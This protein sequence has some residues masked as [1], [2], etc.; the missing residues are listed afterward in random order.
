[1]YPGIVFHIVGYSVAESVA[2]L[3]LGLLAVAV[4]V[5]AV[6][7]V[8]HDLHAAFR[9]TIAPQPGSSASPH[10]AYALS[11]WENQQTPEQPIVVRVSV[12]PTAN[13]PGKILRIRAM[14]LD[15]LR[16]DGIVLP[17]KGRLIILESGTMEF[18]DGAFRGYA[19]MQNNGDLTVYTQDDHL[20]LTRCARHGQ[21]HTICHDS[22]AG[23]A[24]LASVLGEIRHV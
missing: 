19:T 3:I 11:E 15:F 5:K 8:A 20:V 16:N 17:G 4:V 14:A 6:E 9:G 12:D 13:I 1:M 21:F 23:R 10:A 22:D 18:A 24:A 2:P 7:R